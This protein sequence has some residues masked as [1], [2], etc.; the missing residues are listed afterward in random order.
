MGLVSN[1]NLKSAYV[2]LQQREHNKTL[3]CIN[4]YLTEQEE[5]QSE[6]L[7]RRHPESS[8]FLKAIE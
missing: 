8:E 4:K 7:K 2:Q 5:D 1:G 6:L 3:V